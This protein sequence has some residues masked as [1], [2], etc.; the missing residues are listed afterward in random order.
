MNLCVGVFRPSRELLRVHSVAA[1]A[2]VDVGVKKYATFAFKS[3]WDAP[4]D[5]PEPGLFVEGILAA[6][7]PDFENEIMD[8]KSSKPNFERWNA[9]FAE[10]TGGKRVGNLRGQHNPKV[11]AGKFVEMTYDDVGLTIPVT[12]KVIDPGEADKVR[13]GV[14]TSFS[15]GA[16]YV[17][18]WGDGQHVRWTADPFEGSLVDF[19]SIPS[20][21]GFVYRAANGAVK[22]IGGR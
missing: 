14:Y 22:M 13:E 5:D 16:H 2:V 7:E 18:K 21:R 3:A 17:R 19:G 12:A 4:V 9:Q 11:A 6:E 1:K 20:S 8:Y 10:V 15:I